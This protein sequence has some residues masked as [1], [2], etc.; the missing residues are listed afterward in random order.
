MKNNTMLPLLLFSV[1]LF[2]CAKEDQTLPCYPMECYKVEY[3]TRICNFEF[4]NSIPLKSVIPIAD[5]EHIRVTADTTLLPFIKNFCDKSRLQ[6]EMEE[7]F[8]R[9]LNEIRTVQGELMAAIYQEWHTH[10]VCFDLPN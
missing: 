3:K 2:S 10:L 9:N 7:S 6:A 8:Y 4:E 5:K 1:L